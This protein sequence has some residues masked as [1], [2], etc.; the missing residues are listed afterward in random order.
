MVLWVSLSCSDTY[1]AIW[2][3]RKIYEDVI[4][5]IVLPGYSRRLRGWRSGDDQLPAAAETCTAQLWLCLS[6]R[7]L[8][9]AVGLDVCV[10]GVPSGRRFVSCTTSF[11]VR[12]QA[13]AGFLPAPVFAA[14]TSAHWP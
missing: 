1:R 13:L 8:G 5:A 3:R 12:A 7:A 6:G 9:M 10:A 2:N 11:C 4:A 14:G